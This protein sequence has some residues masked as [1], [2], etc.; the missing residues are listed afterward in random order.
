MHILILLLFLLSF[1]SF[2]FQ[3]S[4]LKRKWMHIIIY[5]AVGIG[6]YNAYPFAIEQSYT[7]FQELISNKEII[8]NFLV[9]Q[10]VE[11]ILGIL[12]CIYLI[13]EYFGEKVLKVFNSFHFFPGMIIIPAIFYFESFCFLSI[14]GMNFQMLAIILAIAFPVL[15]FAF[16]RMIQIGIPEYDLRLELK[17]ILHILQLLIAVVISIKIYALPV[18]TSVGTID[19]LPMISLVLLLVVM[20][21]IGMWR[22]KNRLKKLAK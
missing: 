4:L 15:F 20:G 13:R 10:I 14:S 17:F 9:I 21:L 2:V 3:M 11:C 19:Y 16:E 7:K 18:Q 8:S 12:F 6:L 22:Y 5:G 1:A